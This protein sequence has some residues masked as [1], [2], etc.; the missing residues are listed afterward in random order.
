LVWFRGWFETLQL[1]GVEAA[2]DAVRSAERKTIRVVAKRWLDWKREMLGDDRKAYQGCA[3]TLEKWVLPFPIADVD[4]EQDLTLGHCTDWIESVKKVGRASMTTRNVVQGLR[5]FLVNVRGK[6][7]VRL[8]ENPLLDPYVRKLLG[9]AD[10]VAGRNTIIHLTKVQSNQ[11]IVCDSA[12]TP[13]RM[14]TSRPSLSWA[15]APRGSSG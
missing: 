15:T 9:P 12:D 10:T 14:W 4:L 6:G 3:R 1:A 2:N 13:S 11:L 5:G 8:R 7:W